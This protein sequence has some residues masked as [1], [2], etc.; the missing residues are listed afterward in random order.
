MESHTEALYEAYPLQMI[1]PHPKYSY[2]TQGD[3]KDSFINDIKDHRRQIDGH[4][5]WI[6][7]LSSRDAAARGIETD[8]LVKVHNHRGAVVCAALV[9]ERLLPGT[10]MGYEASAVY[11]PL[12]EPGNS[13]DRGGCLNQ[14]TP[15]RTQIAKSHAQGNSA[16]LVEVELW[17][18]GVE[19]AQPTAVA[20]EAKPPAAKSEPVPA[21]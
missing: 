5:Y 2:H 12:G 11:D 7:R 21:E 9:T 10:V 3:G 18:G 14:L 1:T 13:V 6:I 4:F 20:A 19:L 8:D 15:G 17:D 16:A